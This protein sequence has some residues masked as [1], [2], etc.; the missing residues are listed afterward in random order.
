M[1]ARM[2]NGRRTIG[3]DRRTAA[4]PEPPVLTP[5]AASART[6]EAFAQQVKAMFAAAYLRG[7]ISY[8]PW[9]IS[10]DDEVTHP[11]GTHYTARL[12]PA[13]TQVAHIADVMAT[14]RRRSTTVE[15]YPVSVT[16][17]R[18]RAMVWLAGRHASRPDETIAIRDSWVKLDSDDPRIELH[19]AEVY[20][21]RPGG[22]R[23]RVQVPLKH[24]DSG[25]V[26][27]IRPV[28]EDREEFIRVLSELRSRYV[29][30]SDSSTVG[31]DGDRFTTH[32]GRPIDLSNFSEKWWKPVVAAA[33][34]D[35]AEAHLA[36]MPFR[37]LRA[38]AIT[39]WL[40]VLGMGTQE[41]ADRA[42]NTQAVIERHYKGVIDSL[43][44]RRP[45]RT[46]VSTAGS[47]ET[48]IEGLR[49]LDEDELAA[50]M[51]VARKRVKQL[52]ADDE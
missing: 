46:G 30:S 3:C 4:G 23:D 2:R 45:S 26:R 34:T 35:P 18:Y 37:R 52:L 50:V 41:A 1:G 10:V 25:E 17:E 16:G 22:G 32:H 38:A 5:E 49:H 24:R 33:F 11:A 44:P 43:P 15:G 31:T 20:H 13:R 29:S 6:V 14:H 12:L 42:G 21:P 40:V 9:S 27:V 48:I 28:E 47:A 51:L 7:K 8:Q 19:G 39:D 36:D